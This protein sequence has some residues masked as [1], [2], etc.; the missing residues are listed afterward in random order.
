LPGWQQYLDAHPQRDAFAFLSVAVDTEPERVRAFAEPYTYPTAVD[1]ANVLGRLFDFDVVPNGLLIDE[2][3]IVRFLHVG[4]FYLGRPEI[5][6]QVDALLS[7]DFTRDE[8]PAFVTQESLEMETIRG[9]LAHRPEDADLLMALGDALLREERADEAV[10]AFQRAA[11][12]RP[13]DWS[14]AFGLGTALRR[15]EDRAGA[16]RWWRRALELDPRNFTVRKQIW[17]EEHPE[18]FYPTIDTAWQKEQ[19]AKEGYQP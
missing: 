8:L 6:Q 7:A 18:R 16:L 15:Q 14:V 12:S 9:E 13:D 1:T 2:Q 10:A 11:A 3:G 5:R 4:G 19:L 17:R